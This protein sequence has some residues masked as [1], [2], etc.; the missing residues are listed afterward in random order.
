VGRS[1]VNLQTVALFNPTEGYG[2]FVVAAVAVLILQQTLLMGS[3]LLAGTWRAG[4][5]H[6]GA[7]SG[8]H[9]SGAVR[10]GLAGGAFLFW[11]DLRLAGL[12]AWRQPM[13]CSGAAGLL[14]AGG[15]GMRLPAGLVAGEP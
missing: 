12:P 9:G 7:A 8:W 11:L 15:G 2:S 10:A 1:P 4:A 13:G 6:A 14:C 3:A 5:A